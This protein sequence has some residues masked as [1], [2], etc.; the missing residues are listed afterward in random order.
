[1]K[2]ITKSLQDSIDQERT[3]LHLTIT[4]QIITTPADH[5]TPVDQVWLPTVD[6]G[7][8]TL[9]MIAALQGKQLV[10]NSLRDKYFLIDHGC[11]GKDI[12]VCP[13][14]RSA[15]QASASPVPYNTQLHD[16]TRIDD[17]PDEVLIAR[18]NRLGGIGIIDRQDAGP[19]YHDLLLF[20]QLVYQLLLLNIIH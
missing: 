12:A 9:S 1:M 14:W 8:L 7:L 18:L 10:V 2:Q 4:T 16:L 3:K 17:V 11:A 20:W 5:L 6:T 15:F 13:L 19:S